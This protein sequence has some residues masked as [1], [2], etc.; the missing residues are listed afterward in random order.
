MEQKYK[1]KCTQ[2]LGEDL[3][4]LRT[5]VKEVNA[6]TTSKHQQCPT[7]INDA[8][9]ENIEQVISTVKENL[10]E[11]STSTEYYTSK[12]SNVTNGG[13]PYKEHIKTTKAE[14]STF[15]A[16]HAQSIQQASVTAQKN[17][18]VLTQYIWIWN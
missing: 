3:A 10:S 5:V 13:T 15:V 2:N 6:S 18:S 12:I 16:R 17:F 8:S 14:L 9:D 1:T 7:F 11:F 4:S